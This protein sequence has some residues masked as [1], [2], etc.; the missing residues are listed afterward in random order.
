MLQTQWAWHQAAG[1]SSTHDVIKHRCV[2][3]R[4]EKAKGEQHEKSKEEDTKTF[5]KNI[6]KIEDDEMRVK[7]SRH[8]QA[9]IQS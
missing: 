8:L 2:S 1:I 3:S 9:R 4:H 6:S 5:K 7:E